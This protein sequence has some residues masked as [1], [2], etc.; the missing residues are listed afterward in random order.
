MISY[1]PL[2]VPFNTVI[3]SLLNQGKI[4]IGMLIELKNITDNLT[5]KMLINRIMHK[6]E[7]FVSGTDKFQNAD[8]IKPL[9]TN[10]DFKSPELRPDK[11]KID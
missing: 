6:L 4:T 8:N 1:T 7:I 3:L 9:M 11:V 10:W 5:Y 2:L